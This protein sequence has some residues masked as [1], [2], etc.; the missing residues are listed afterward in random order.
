MTEQET[1]LALH[2]IKNRQ[3]KQPYDIERINV[4]SWLRFPLIM[5]V[6]LAHCNLYALAESWEGAY[7]EWPRWL[8]CIF[9]E[10]YLIVLPARVPALFI[11]SGYLFFRSEK[12]RGKSFFIYKYKRRVH[13]LLIPYMAW[14]TIAIILLFIRFSIVNGENYT[15][16]DYLSGYWNFLPR[17]NGDPADGP[18]WFMRD[19]IVISLSAPILHVFLK[20]RITGMAFLTLAIIMNILNIA[21]PISGFS[22][23]AIVFFSIGAYMALHNIDFTRIPGFA[24]ITAA[25]LYIPSQLVLNNI[26]DNSEYIYA[27][28]LITAVIKITATF[29]IVSMLFRKNRL[30]PTPKLTR[31]C[32]T[33]YALHGIIAG[34]IIKTLYCHIP[35]NGNPV[36]LLAIYITTV[37][38]IVALTAI[39][40]TKTKQYFPKVSGIL[41]GNRE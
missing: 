9:N 2:K 5:G 29:Y 12:P 37:L 41:S 27:A 28:Y 3:M 7:P 36:A 38:I 22:N 25:L 10:L 20:K 6:V 24:G 13:S 14:N 19:L 34:P 11:I 21:I 39:I 16:A 23:T 18:L 30:S 32:F 17:S 33:L 1:L 8:I 15:A 40:V 31:L 4:M 26:S 35:H